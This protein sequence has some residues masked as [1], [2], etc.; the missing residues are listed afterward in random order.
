MI[1]KDKPYIWYGSYL[2]IDV[3]LYGKNPEIL[4]LSSHRK[5]VAMKEAQAI[6][7]TAKNI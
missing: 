5:P 1:D 6:I 3:S 4:W 2:L 7:S